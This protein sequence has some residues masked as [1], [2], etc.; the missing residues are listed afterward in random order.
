[1]S[2]DNYKKMLRDNISKTYK[3]AGVGVK[4]AIDRDAGRIATELGIAERV[5][6]CATKVAYITL[7]D[8]KENFWNR[9]ACRLINPAKSEIGI[10]S[11][12]IVEQLNSDIRAA[13]GLRQWHNTQSVIH[14]FKNLQPREN[15]SFI[16][17][18]IVEFYPSITE[19]LLRKAINFAK[20]HTTI[21]GEQQQVIW[22]ARKSLLFDHDK[23]W[24]KRNGGSFDVTMGSFDGAE[25]C[26]LVGLFMLDNLSKHFDKECI[27]LYRDDGLSALNL[28]GRRAEKAR[29]TI[30][31]IFKECGLRVTVDPLQRRTDFLDVNLDLDTGKYWPYR[32]PNSELLYIN[33]QSNHPPSILKQLPEAITHRITSLSCDAEEFGKAMPAYKEA[34][35]KVGHKT[36]TTQLPVLAT[37]TKK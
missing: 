17:F 33:A 20:L 19:E 35:E 11:K 7:K 16:K 31:Q 10:V 36:T 4:Q 25:I 1:M 8:H 29:Q 34:L 3:P 13:T 23:T 18:D 21:S 28:T 26:E 2:R 6:I 22:H 30:T 24:V 14:W 27:G 32:K 5:E 9:P 37:S 15:T 12:H